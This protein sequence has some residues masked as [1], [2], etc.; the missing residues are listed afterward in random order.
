MSKRK[1]IIKTLDKIKNYVEEPKQ[2][3]TVE[4]LQV[5][6]D[7]CLE[8]IREN[9]VGSPLKVLWPTFFNLDK[10]WWANDGV[11]I[12]ALR[13]R[14]V[15]IIPTMCDQIQSDECM[16]FG[17][18]WQESDKPN[19]KE[20]RS[21]L[22]N[23]CTKF[24]TQFWSTLRINP[25]KLS[26]FVSSSEIE[27][28]QAISQEI[29]DGDWQHATYN[30]FPIGY[31]AWKAVINNDLKANIGDEWS[32]TAQKRAY[33]HIFNILILLKAYERVFKLYQPDRIVGN[34][35]FYY[36]WGIPAHFAAA[37]DIPYYRYYNVG[38]HPPFSWNYNRNKMAL[39]DF[40]DSWK[41]WHLQE[42]SDDRIERVKKD[43]F[44]RGVKLDDIQTQDFQLRKKSIEQGFGIDTEKP[45]ILFLTGVIYDANSN[46]PSECFNDMYEWL[47]NTIEW[48]R[49]RSDYQFVI[50]VHPGENYV[51]SIGTDERSRFMD[52][53][54]KR[55]INLPSNVII[56]PP[57]SKASTYDMMHMCDFAVAYC[58]TSGLEYACH[59]KPLICVGPA[60]YK[61]KSFTIDPSDENDYYATIDSLVKTPVTKDKI[62]ANQLL[63]FK[64]WYFYAYHGSIVT[65]LLE[66]TQQPTAIQKQGMASIVTT[67]KSIT[68]QD[69]LPG[70]NPYI[71]FL[72]DSIIQNLPIDAS[73]RWAPELN[74]EEAYL[75]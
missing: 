74:L 17:G 38:L 72:C 7:S 63:A 8:Y 35:G 34:G 25:I 5:L 67:L 12:N 44:I 62:K 32:G 10:L 49:A 14:G 43:I 65:G 22:C 71:D 59:G 3:V 56:I 40:S 41:T 31:E 29:S 58:S 75:T 20:R 28:I 6:T 55:Q 45:F 13:I 37:S 18:V 36:Y 46:G 60:H 23:M 47:F 66:N 54:S 73:D 24:D 52:E 61:Y 69:I 33:H 1:I 26:A 30:D 51:D 70:V 9:N 15:E 64:Y 53:V 48:A 16:I 11:L 68:V 19:F 39:I 21:E 4:R 50:R 27:E 2:N 42:L 57:D